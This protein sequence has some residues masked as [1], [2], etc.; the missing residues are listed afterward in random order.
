MLGLE[1]G[2]ISKD[3][4]TL[5][6]H[7]KVQAIRGSAESERSDSEQVDHV[8]SVLTVLRRT[9]YDGANQFSRC[10]RMEVVSQAKLISEASDCQ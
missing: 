8:G 7:K 4:C 9:A 10:R 3:A 5:G 6:M 2:G 1:S